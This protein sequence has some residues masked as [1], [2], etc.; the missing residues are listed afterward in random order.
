[1]PLVA[2][3]ATAATGTGPSARRQYSVSPDRIP[4]LKSLRWCAPGASTGALPRFDFTD[5]EMTALLAH[6]HGLANETIQPPPGR[7]GGF[8]GNAPFQPHRGHS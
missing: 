3:S 4:T 2:Q 7:G 5:D 6:I 8:P 1:L